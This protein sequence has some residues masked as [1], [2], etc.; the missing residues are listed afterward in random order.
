MHLVIAT[1]RAQCSYWTYTSMAQRPIYTC[2]YIHASMIDTMTYIPVYK[3]DTMTHFLLKLPN[4]YNIYTQSTQAKFV[5][6]KLLSNERG[7]PQPEHVTNERGRPQPE[8]VTNER[9][10]PQPDPVAKSPGKCYYV[11]E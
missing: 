4:T 2:M 10:R 3:H 6:S 8:H 5:E 11:V 1:N 9:G 7:R